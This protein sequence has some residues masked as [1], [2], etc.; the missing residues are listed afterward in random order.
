MKRIC[1]GKGVYLLTQSITFPLWRHPLFIISCVWLTVK[2]LLLTDSFEISL[3]SIQCQ[4]QS[5]NV[6]DAVL[7]TKTRILVS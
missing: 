7:S 2:D 1:S 6:T 3:T 4:K 5:T